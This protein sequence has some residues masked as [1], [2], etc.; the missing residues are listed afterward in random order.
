MNIAS[1]APRT[2]SAPLMPHAHGTIWGA[3]ALSRRIPVGIGTPSVT[4]IGSRRVAATAIRIGLEKGT[5]QL[6]IGPT[7]AT[8]ASDTHAPATAAR[9]PLARRPAPSSRLLHAAP[10]PVPSRSEN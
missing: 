8:I 2:D 7:P 5:A 1:V 6:T 3:W 10:R 4:P 9:T